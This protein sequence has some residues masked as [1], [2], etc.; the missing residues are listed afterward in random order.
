MTDVSTQ[1]V[2]GEF[3]VGAT[4]PPFV[5]TAGLH[6]WNRFAAVNYEFVDIHMDDEAG[7][8]AGYPRAFGMGN[9]TYA[10]MHCLLREWLADDGW[11]VRI[12]CQFRRPA[13]RGDVVTCRAVV[14]RT[15]EEDGVAMAD[16]DVWTED[17]ATIPFSFS[18]MTVSQ[19]RPRSPVRISSPCSL[20]AGARLGRE[21]SS[22]NCTGVVTSGTR[23][24]SASSASST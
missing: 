7:R 17:Q 6:A 9:L 8:A 16:L 15:Y 20:N 18:S 19:S 2:A 22:S 5:R 12:G 11:I 10:W 14:A 4:V 23:V 1:A 21:G 24:P 13:L 3:E